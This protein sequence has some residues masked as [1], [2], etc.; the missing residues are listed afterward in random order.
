ME[1]LKH[2]VFRSMNEK[3]QVTKE[4]L[5]WREK[6]NKGIEKSQKSVRKAEKHRENERWHRKA[7]NNPRLHSWVPR[8]EGSQ[9][10][11]GKVIKITLVTDC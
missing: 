7:E 9:R 10:H 3:S 2:P 1:D 8:G 4:G 6:E 11:K 5:F